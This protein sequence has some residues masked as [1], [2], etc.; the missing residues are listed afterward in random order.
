[1]DAEDC[2]FTIGRWEEKLDTTH[3]PGMVF[4]E[5]GLV[6]KH[7]KTSTKIRFNTFDALGS[8]KKEALPSIEVLAAAQWKF[9]WELVVGPNSNEHCDVLFWV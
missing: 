8:W 4:G 5:S 3:L 1:M 6:L 9:R 2:E 7:D